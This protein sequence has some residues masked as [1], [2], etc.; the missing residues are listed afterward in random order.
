MLHFLKSLFK[1][2]FNAVG[3]EKNTRGQLLIPDLQIVIRINNFCFYP[4]SKSISH[5]KADV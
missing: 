4:L 2:K 5:P 3:S 1:S